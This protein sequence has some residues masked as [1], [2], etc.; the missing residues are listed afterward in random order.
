MPLVSLDGTESRRRPDPQLD[1]LADH[2][3][4]HQVEAEQNFVEVERL[5]LEDLLAAEREKLLREG[6]PVPGRQQDRFGRRSRVG[7][8]EPGSDEVCVP[9][10]RREQVVEVVGDPGGEL[11]EPLH[12]LRLPKCVL[13]LPALG[14]IAGDRDHRV[15]GAVRLRDRGEGDVDRNQAA[16]LPLRL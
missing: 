2:A 9:E 8:L 11:A 1:V 5:G 7:A 16:V 13:E 4:Q 10:H 3:P 14:E 12:L 6:R 15:E